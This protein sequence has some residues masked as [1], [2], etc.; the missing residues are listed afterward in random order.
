M[1]KSSNNIQITS[2]AN[3]ESFHNL[4]QAVENDLA[5]NAISL[6]KKWVIEELFKQTNKIATTKENKKK[7]SS[8]TDAQRM[9]IICVHQ[10]PDQK[11]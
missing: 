3:E 7:K 6:T 8:I 5:S 4:F 11:K 1:E 2:W 10:T 9:K